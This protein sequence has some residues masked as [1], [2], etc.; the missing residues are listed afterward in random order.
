MT[1]IVDQR[2]LLAAGIR[3][4]DAPLFGQILAAVHDDLSPSSIVDLDRCETIAVLLFQ[5]VLFKIPFQEVVIGP[6]TCDPAWHERWRE[7][8][9]V[10]L[11]KVI[12]EHTK[13][14]ERRRK[15][16][17]EQRALEA[18]IRARPQQG[19][20]PPK[21]LTAKEAVLEALAFHEQLDITI[22]NALDSFVKSDQLRR[23]IR[24]RDVDL[25]ELDE[26][27][28]SS[29][30]C[31]S[32]VTESNSPQSGNC[33]PHRANGQP[34]A[35]R[36]LI[37]ETICPVAVCDSEKERFNE[38]LDRVYGDFRPSGFLA[39]EACYTI[40]GLLV[41][42][43]WFKIFGE[44]TLRGATIL[45]WELT[46]EER[47]EIDL[48][49]TETLLC[50]TEEPDRRQQLEEKRQALITRI[51]ARPRIVRKIEEPLHSKQRFLEAIAFQKKL[52]A[53]IARATRRLV[54]LQVA[55]SRAA[56]T[57]KAFRLFERTP[58]FT[59]RGAVTH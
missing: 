20:N 30:R 54:K 22:E 23:S 55:K 43:Q 6:A 31:G 32:P 27:S 50:V 7:D 24:S 52:D 15:I 18:K 35:Y 38:M 33:E 12:L 14:P 36:N 42:K 39:S 44:P 37:A 58:K 49:I 56:R 41:Q 1:G 47:D 4:C 45:A 8:S 28:S 29:W 19:P 57:P 10:H 5:K 2:R 26:Q 17:E 3:E 51:E 59:L 34:A 13:D 11:S 48:E 9:L 25:G 46:E 21:P 40:A 53:G 16:E